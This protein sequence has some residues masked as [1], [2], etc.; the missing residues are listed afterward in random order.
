M[1]VT[2]VNNDVHRTELRVYHVGNEGTTRD[3][4]DVIIP[5]EDLTNLDDSSLEIT[6]RIQEWKDSGSF[7]VKG[8]STVTGESYV[9]EITSGDR[10]EF[11][12]SYHEQG[13]E[14][15]FGEGGYGLDYGEGYG[16]GESTIITERRW[17]GWAQEPARATNGARR[18][19]LVWDATDFVFETLS[20]RLVSDAFAETEIAGPSDA[21]VNRLVRSH[22]PEVDRSGIEDVDT[23]TDREFDGVD[24]KEVCSDLSETADAL[25]AS[26]GMELIYRPFEDI[27]VKHS[28][29]WTDIYNEAAV[30]PSDSELVNEW[31]IDGGTGNAEDEIQEDV[32]D[33]QL[34]TEDDPL[35]YELDPE[36]NRIDHIDI[37]TRR[38]SDDDNL[39]VGIQKSNSEGDAPRDVSDES[40]DI[41][42]DQSEPEFISQDDW[43]ERFD[44]SHEPLT[45][46][47]WLIIR[48]GGDE[49]HEIGLNSSGDPA[50]RTYYPF[51]VNVQVSDPDSID[52]Y[53]LRQGRKKKDILSTFDAARD[54]G[55]GALRHSTFPDATFACEA[56]S[57]R[58]HQLEPGEVVDAD[59]PELGVSGEHIVVE[60]SETY[61]ATNNRLTTELTL[62]DMSTI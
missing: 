39:T 23:T 25:M 43:R 19:M 16:G 18:V 30:E 6:R 47:P 42:S 5:G 17:T 33:Y 40:K 4:A 28:L 12:A 29:E 37:W 27:P 21:I 32:D 26:D 44:F 61:D 53:R 52:E 11:W 36:K 3:D 9:G 48:A 49:G 7:S 2:L 58:A 24:L 46:T 34:V 10:F 57:L 35:V 20:Q 38:I 55:E 22:A 13:V 14:P 50:I 60:R 8:R 54:V 51:P 31:R 1:T 56:R 41:V 59:F 62:Q 15:E 45:D